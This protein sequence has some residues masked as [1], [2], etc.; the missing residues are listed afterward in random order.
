MSTHWG[1]AIFATLAAAACAPAGP[2]PE[3]TADTIYTGGPIVTVNDAQPSAARSR[4]TRATRRSAVGVRRI[5]WSGRG[6]R[7]LWQVHRFASFP[8]GSHCD[9]AA[10]TTV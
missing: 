8:H 5:G 3:Q 10:R 7:Q 9:H 4:D 6:R 2:M 1:I